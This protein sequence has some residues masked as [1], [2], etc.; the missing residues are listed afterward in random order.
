MWTSLQRNS[1][2]WISR[3]ASCLNCAGTGFCPCCKGNGLVMQWVAID[4]CSSCQGHGRT[5]LAWCAACGGLGRTVLSEQ[6]VECEECIGD[7]SC[8]AC[9]GVA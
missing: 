9:G 7:G 5:G 4:V 3:M 2:A 1:K 8:V 6:L